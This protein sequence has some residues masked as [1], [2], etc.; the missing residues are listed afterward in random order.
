MSNVVPAGGPWGPSA[1]VLSAGRSVRAALSSRLTPRRGRPGPVPAGGRLPS[2]SGARVPAAILVFGFHMQIAGLYAKGSA[3][4][5][6]SA[7]LFEHGTMRVSFFFLLSGFVLAWAARPGEAKRRTWRKRAARVFPIHAVTALVA[8]AGAA[9]AS[10]A[11]GAH[12]L[13]VVLP[14]LFLVQSWVPDQR[15]YFGLNTVSWSLSCE[16]FFYLVFPFAMR[17]LTRLDPRRLWPAAA[18]LVA[19]VWSLP[20]LTSGWS[21]PLAYW[22]I[23][24]FPPVRA[25]EFVLGMVM[26][27]IVRQGR[28]VRLPVWVP[29]VTV[30]AVYLGVGYLPVRIGYVAAALVPLALLVPALA[31]ADL[32]GRR[33][34]WAHPRMVWLGELTFAFYL[35]HQLVIRFTLKLLHVPPTGTVGWDTAHSATVE[36]AALLC[37]FTAALLLNRGVELPLN[38]RLR[39]RAAPA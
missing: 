9:G 35:V 26:A 30:L 33:W 25:L 2:L 31:Q 5:A 21:Q 22:F 6:T 17:A 15:V 37:A 34:I 24:V 20:V 12:S 10:A 1:G 16:A 8:L 11:A 18:A 4:D 32:D 28:W 27:Q 19:V 23:Y 14:G 7:E 13:G 29:T 36:L 3:A 38:D 39:G